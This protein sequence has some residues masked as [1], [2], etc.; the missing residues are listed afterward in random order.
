[1]DDDF[2]AIDNI[3]RKVGGKGKTD[4]LVDGADRDAAATKFAKSMK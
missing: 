2:A 3:V 4:G 1:M